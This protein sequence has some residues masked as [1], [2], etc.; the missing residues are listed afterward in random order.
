[1][2][3]FRIFGFELRLRRVPGPVQAAVENAAKELDEETLKR[4]F[5]LLD[6]DPRWKA[7]RFVTMRAIDAAATN[8]TSPRMASDHGS[9]AWCTGG[10]AHL[11]QFLDG[12]LE[13]RERALG[14]V[15][16]EVDESN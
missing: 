7:W 14:D 4:A 2:K 5:G 11:R 1:M 10:V 12:I 16:P 9:L 3:T 8:A 6:N 13:I 15:E